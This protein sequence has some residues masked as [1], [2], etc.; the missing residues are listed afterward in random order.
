MS[1]TFPIC[2][3]WFP[4][5][6]FQVFCHFRLISVHTQR[7]VR[8][9]WRAERMRT[10][11][12]SCG[13]SSRPYWLHVWAAFQNWVSVLTSFLSVC[14]VWYSLFYLFLSLLSIMSIMKHWVIYNSERSH[15]S[16][17]LW[18]GYTRWNLSVCYCKC[19]ILNIEC[20]IELL[21]YIWITICIGFS[22]NSAK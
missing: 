15:L 8:R 19:H 7:D 18:E 11:N 12:W 20:N 5:F 4:F 17:S 9:D 10:L 22:I 6:V 13:H 3:N 16:Y 14:Y 2:L 1:F 21:F